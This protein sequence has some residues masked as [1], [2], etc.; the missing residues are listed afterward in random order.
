MTHLHLIYLF[1]FSLLVQLLPCRTRAPGP[2]A[3]LFPPCIPFQ[4]GNALGIPIT[5]HSARALPTG[6]KAL[7]KEPNMPDIH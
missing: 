3:S 5:A 1:M 4:H 7:R 2:A 6:A